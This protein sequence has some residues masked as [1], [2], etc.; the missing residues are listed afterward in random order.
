MKVCISKKKFGDPHDLDYTLHVNT[1]SLGFSL[2]LKTGVWMAAYHVDTW[3]ARIFS[4]YYYYCNFFCCHH[5]TIVITIAYL[6]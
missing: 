4:Y 5:H 3:L 6:Y 2:L 1:L